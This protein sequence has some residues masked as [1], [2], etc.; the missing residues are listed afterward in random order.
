[1]GILHPEVIFAFHLRF[2]ISAL[3][4]NLE[5]IINQNKQKH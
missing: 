4:L 2:P 3:E 5:F 1:M